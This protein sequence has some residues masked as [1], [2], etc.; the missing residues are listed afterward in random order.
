M[1]NKGL[2]SEIL[3]GRRKISADMAKRLAAHFQ[4]PVEL[5]L[6]CCALLTS[7]R[8]LRG[9]QAANHHY[10]GPMTAA[11]KHIVSSRHGLLSS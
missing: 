5:F 4:V 11:D 6:D 7:F 8:F 9:L 1:G 10:A 3:H 2:T